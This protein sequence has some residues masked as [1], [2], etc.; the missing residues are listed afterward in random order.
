MQIKQGCFYPRP[1]VTQSDPKRVWILPF[2]GWVPT[3]AP[4]GYLWR[5]LVS[6][7]DPR[8][9]TSKVSNR[10]GIL[11]ILFVHIMPIVFFD[12]LLCM[13]EFKVQRTSLA[14]M[15]KMKGENGSYYFRVHFVPPHNVIYVRLSHGQCP[16]RP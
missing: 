7:G 12:Q 15:Y 2:L 4:L 5:P 10:V 9:L 1:T 3:K 6:Q 16:P 8:R 13:S 11:Q 14:Q